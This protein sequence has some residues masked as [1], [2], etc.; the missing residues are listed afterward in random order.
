MKPSEKKLFG[1]NIVA[2]YVKIVIFS[3]YPMILNTAKRVK[4]TVEA[5]ETKGFSRSAKS[6]K[7]MELK[8]SN[9]KISPRDIKVL[10][11]ISLSMV[12]AILI[13]QIV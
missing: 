5:L 12:F 6:R 1:L 8:F 4:M 13:G 9:M 3:F 10:S 7:V 2:Y 11:A